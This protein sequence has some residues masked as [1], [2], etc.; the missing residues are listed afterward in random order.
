VPESLKVTIVRDVTTDGYDVKLHAAVPHAQLSTGP[1]DL[2]LLHGEGATITR[3]LRNTEG[4]RPLV[5][6]IGEV[7][8]P[9]GT[10]IGGGGG[11]GG[12]SE[13]PG[14][15]VVPADANLGARTSRSV[16]RNA[17]IP[18]AELLSGGGGYIDRWPTHMT[19]P[20]GVGYRSPGLISIS[21]AEDVLED[22][23]TTQGEQKNEFDLSWADS[24]AG[25]LAWDE[26]RGVMWHVNVGGDNGIY[27]IDPTDGS[28]VDVITGTPW[29]G[30]SQRGLAYDP[31]TDT[32]YIG[33]WNEGIVYQ[34][35]GPSWPTPGETIDSCQPDD[36]NISGLA[37]NPAFQKL[38]EATNSRHD[39]IWLIDPRTCEAERAIE[40]PDPRY[41]GAGL[42][43][44]A[45]GNLWTVSQDSRNAYLLASG[46][47]TFSD[48]PWLTVRPGKGEIQPGHNA[49]LTIH[50]DTDGVAPGSYRA[51][52][53]VKTNDPAKGVFTIPIHL[54]L[55]KY[56]RHVNVGGADVTFGDGTGY[57][58]DRPFRDDGFGYVGD[59]SSKRVDHTIAATRYQAVFRSQRYGMDAYR[60]TVP[61]GRYRVTLEFAELTAGVGEFDRIMDIYA[62]GDLVLD[63]LDVAA[64]VGR[65]QALTRTFRVQVKDGTLRLRFDRAN[66][67]PPML[68]GVRVTWLSRD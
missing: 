18:S 9:P 15:Y 51:F 20:W 45:V 57:V 66:G 25:D 62:Q 43:M 47:P 49:E 46:L 40:H 5:F 60:F 1:V 48:V 24:W 13:P 65:Y 12:G 68:N 37:W 14:P 50:I 58:A 16:D 21:D 2:T 33:G 36:G 30:I 38:W 17:P 63:N 59:S 28:V 55:T 35:A 39:T 10:Q 67:R 61:D 8:V 26:A 54:L 19:L 22:V 29:G 52:V 23:F 6:E 4:H 42:E 31:A 56:Q 34:V 44:D 11:G 3:V 7:N 41:N 64:R 27:G 53:A 32:F